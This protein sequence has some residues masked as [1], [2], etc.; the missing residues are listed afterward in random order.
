MKTVVATA[1]QSADI[2]F[3]LN[4]IHTEGDIEYQGRNVVKSITVADTKWNIKIFKIPHIINKLAYRF[5]R[6]S[7][8]QRSFEYA[9]ILLE[10][11]FNTPTPIAYSEHRSALFLL[12]S[13]Y[14]TEHLDYQLSFRTLKNNPQY[15]DRRNILQQFTE[16]TYKLQMSGIHFIDHSPGNTLIVKQNDQS[17]RFYLVDLNR[18]NFGS[19]SYQARIENFTRLS[20]TDEMI[21]IIALKYAELCGKD[22]QAVYADML[23]ACHTYTDK[24]AKSTAW[25]KKLKALIKLSSG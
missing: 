14:I 20:L 4:R 18:M 16:F 22:G 23:N 24:R 2:Q 3:V 8:A 12:D 1:Y 6:K 5:F 9:H 25:K 13:Y 10:K 15:P 11:G 21:E 17:Y 19:L 7:K